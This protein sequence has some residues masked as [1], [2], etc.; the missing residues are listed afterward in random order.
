MK[1][2]HPR[3]KKKAAKRHKNFLER[4]RNI[5]TPPE[6]SAKLHKHF[7]SDRLTR[8]CLVSLANTLIETN[9]ELPKLKKAANRMDAFFWFTKN[10]K[11]VEKFIGVI[12]SEMISEPENILG[13]DII[14]K[15]DEIEDTYHIDTSD[16]DELSD[17]S[18]QSVSEEEE[19]VMLNHDI[20]DEELND[21]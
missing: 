2:Q 3:P 21:K 11:K 1:I 9:P 13:N 19:P 5:E 14:N 4:C 6:I 12:P 18:L 15:D 20:Y 7:N 16:D 17:N 10:W 8:K